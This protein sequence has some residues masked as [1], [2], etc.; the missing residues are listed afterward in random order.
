MDAEILFVY[1]TSQFN[2]V[3]GLPSKTFNALTASRFLLGGSVIG[4]IS[5]LADGP[6][7]SN[8]IVLIASRALLD[9]PA[10]PKAMR[11]RSSF[12]YIS[13]YYLNATF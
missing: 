2:M 4:Q 12:K 10:N 8:L 6:S 7:N 13:F 3:I 5:Q 9:G 11:N 1:V